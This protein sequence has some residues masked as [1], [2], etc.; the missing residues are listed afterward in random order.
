MLE[1]L[2][3]HSETLE[4]LQSSRAVESLRSDLRFRKKDSWRTTRRM[5]QSGKQITRRPL[6]G[7][8][9]KEEGFDLR[10]GPWNGKGLDRA[11]GIL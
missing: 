2:D 1:S 9:V 6:W 7:L 8:E 3:G 5:D 10:Q 11:E 4:F